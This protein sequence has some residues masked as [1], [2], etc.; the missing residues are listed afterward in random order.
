M[1]LATE[2][3]RVNISATD[4]ES[5]ITVSI[6]TK[7]EQ[8]GAITIPSK[9]MKE[10]IGSLSPERVDFRVDAATQTM[11]VR[12]GI[13]TSELRG[14]D[15]DEYP[16]IRHDDG[17][18]DVHMEVE[19]LLR[20]LDAVLKCTAR[21]QNRPILCGVH[22]YLG[23]G[24]IELA[25][26]DG[27]RLGIEHLPVAYNGPERRA[28][29]P[30]SAVKKL[31]RVLR[32]LKDKELGI[33]FVEHEDGSITQVRFV[34][35]NIQVTAQLLGERIPDYASIVPRS[36]V[37][38]VVLYANDVRIALKR[39]AI[40]ARDN[41]NS[42]YLT[43]VPARHPGEPAEV[44]IGAKSPDKGETE[45]M[46]DASAEGERFAWSFNCKYLLEAVEPYRKDAERIVIDTNG[47][48]DPAVIRPEY[49]PL[50][51]VGEAGSITVIMS[52]SK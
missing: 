10:L 51:S 27:Y 15:A 7:I 6:G 25:G 36:Y 9:T 30:G 2:D 23:K 12:C 16:T 28:V 44:T 20:M 31:L 5:S 21:E 35:P 24:K 38:Q 13:Q 8:P 33:R 11:N 48:Q 19:S 4:L 42:C 1:L 43:V 29:L 49:R 52:M 41:A 22:L 45:A 17:L 37:S 34:L 40:F 32:Q 46:L 26:T 39:A 47:P 18:S 14:I 3:S 50:P